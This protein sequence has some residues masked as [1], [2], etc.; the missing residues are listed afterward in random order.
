MSSPS[1]IAKILVQQ[2]NSA[3]EVVEVMRVFFIYQHFL[4]SNLNHCQQKIACESFWQNSPC[5]I[6][7]FRRF[8][9]Q[10]CRLAAKELSD[11]VKPVLDKNNIRLEPILNR[12]LLKLLS[13]TQLL[14]A[15][16]H[17]TFITFLPDDHK[18]SSLK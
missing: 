15:I 8:G 2:V 9:C 7:F 4:L 13:N 18:D 14:M 12:N 3:G 5:V 17:Q 10:F 6:I 1:R 11:T 16:V